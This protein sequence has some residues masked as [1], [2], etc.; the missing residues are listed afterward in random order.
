MILFYLLII[1]LPL[2]DHPLFARPISRHHGREISGARLLLL[3]L[4]LPAESR[5]SVPRILI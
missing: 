2:V 5:K 1:S 4:V 3:R